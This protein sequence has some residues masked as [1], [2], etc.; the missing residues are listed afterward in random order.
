[1]ALPIT[2][3]GRCCALLRRQPHVELVHQGQAL[4][5]AQ[6]GRARRCRSLAS[7]LHLALEHVDVANE[8]EG[9]LRFGA[10]SSGP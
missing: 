9:D 7:D 8:L 5:P 1:M 10:P 3:L 4:F 6:R 2:L